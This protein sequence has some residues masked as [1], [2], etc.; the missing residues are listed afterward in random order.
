M[1]YTELQ[2]LQKKITAANQHK[3]VPILFADITGFTEY[4]RNREPREVVTMLN[5]LFSK[6]DELCELHNVFKVYTIGD[7][8]VVIGFKDSKNLIRNPV[9]EIVNTLKFAFD[10]RDSID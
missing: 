7:C 1:P 3:E 4:S 8:Y 2:N 9:K 6:F 10:M 5:I